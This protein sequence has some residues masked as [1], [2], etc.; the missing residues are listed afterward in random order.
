[1]VII[2]KLN[3]NLYN[4]V[5]KKLKIGI[6]FVGGRNFTGRICM[7]HRS[8]GVKRNY[9]LIDFYRRINS[10]GIIYKIIK[11]LNRTAF[12]GSIIYENGLFSFIILSEGLQ[13]GDKIYSGSKKKFLDKLKNGFALPLNV[14][15]LFTIVSNIEFK[16][17]TGSKFSRA[18]GTSCLLIGKKKNTIILKFR[19]GWNIYISKYCIIVIGHVSNMVHK[20]INYKKAGRVII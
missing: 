11:D 15:N 20:F 4:F 7:H 6:F 14:V 3:Y 5:T 16:P 13:V 12:I 9:C 8:G 2:K 10:F 18:A 19:S 17:Y 1:M